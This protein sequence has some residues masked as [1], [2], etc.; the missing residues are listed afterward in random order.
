MNIRTLVAALAYSL[1]TSVGFAQ[2]SVLENDPRPRNPA[3]LYQVFTKEAWTNSNFASEQ[4]LKWFKDAKYGM[5]I[6]FG[7]ST[8]KNA[9]LSWGMCGTRKAPDCGAGPY[10]TAVWTA[11]TNEFKLPDFDAEKLVEYAKDAGMKYIVVI[12]KHHDGFHLWD[13][14]F[15]DFKVTRTPFGRDFLKEIA[16]ACHKAGLKFGI[17][18]SQRDWYHPDYCPVDPAKVTQ[19]GTSWKLKPGETDPSG[20]SHKKYIEYQFNVC[21]ELCTKYGRVDIFWFDAA[22]WGGMFTPEMWDAE[23]LTRMIRKLQPGI[24][25]NNRASVPGDF[26]TPEQRIGMF[27]DQRPW[28]S[29]MCLCDSWSY[30]PSRIKSPA[31]IIRILASTACGDGNLLMSWGMQWSGAFHPGQIQS[32]KDTGI[33]LKTNGEAIYETRGGPWLPGKWGGSTYKDNVVYLH[34]LS[35]QDREILVLPG[36]DQKILTAKTMNGTDVIFK[37][38]KGR[39]ELTVPKEIQKP[40]DTIIKLTLDGAVKSVIRETKIGS[41]FDDAAYGE[42]IKDEIFAGHTNPEGK[43]WAIID[44]GKMCNVKGIMIKN[45]IGDESKRTDTKV[46]LSDDGSTWSEAWKSSDT[47]DTWEIPV[48]SYVAGAYIPGRKARYIKIERN[49]KNPDSLH[50]QSIKIYGTKY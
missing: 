4:E 12:A 43:P 36:I 19:S 38:T 35:M 45:T 11:W 48:T 2:W 14:E 44:L 24:V 39:V 8:Y 50:L 9:D 41:I 25:I 18:Y 10:P 46:S 16:D 32:L 21:K 47:A 17:Y 27:Q 28:E 6:H 3:V 30:S 1:I 15:S 49:L 29:C 26:D 13:T 22:Y 42:V 7:L 23:N 40:E 20:T 37:Q 33:W 31:E 5:F 34:I